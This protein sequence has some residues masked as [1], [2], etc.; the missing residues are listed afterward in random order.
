MAIT[1]SK[2]GSKRIERGED[3]NKVLFTNPTLGKAIYAKKYT[4]KDCAHS[5]TEGEEED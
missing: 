2:C 3:K 1:C 4:C 5:W